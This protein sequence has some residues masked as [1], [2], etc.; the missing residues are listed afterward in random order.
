MFC[1]YFLSYRKP[2]KCMYCKCVKDNLPCTALCKCQGCRNN[3]E[4]P[5]GEVEDGENINE[6]YFD[7]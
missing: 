3:K 7:Y 6:D 4:E 1:V 2:D 5:T